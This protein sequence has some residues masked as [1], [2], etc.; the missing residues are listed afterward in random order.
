MQRPSSQQAADDLYHGG[1]ANIPLKQPGHA[2][3]QRPDRAVTTLRRIRQAIQ[4]ANPEA[5]RVPFRT[6]NRAR[7]NK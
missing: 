4:E 7:A 2:E 3:K 1:V 5:R 6:R